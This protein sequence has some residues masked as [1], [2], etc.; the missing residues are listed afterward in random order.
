M[1]NFVDY[2]LLSLARDLW[3]VNGGGCWLFGDVKH[4][5]AQMHIAKVEENKMNWQRE[6]NKVTV[7]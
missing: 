7:S 4:T 5:H 1:K 3:M 2:I 6:W